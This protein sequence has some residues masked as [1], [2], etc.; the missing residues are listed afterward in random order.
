MLL[1]QNNQLWGVNMACFIPYL[2]KYNIG[3]KC[4]KVFNGSIDSIDE[5][6]VSAGG[7]IEQTYLLMGLLCSVREPSSL[8]A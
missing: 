8:S 5:E 3:S 1:K 7:A 2:S 4:N 6:Y